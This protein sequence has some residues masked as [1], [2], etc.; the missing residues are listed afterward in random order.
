MIVLE[1]NRNP[2]ISIIIPTFNCGDF[3]PTAIESVIQQNYAHIEIVIIDGGSTDCTLDVIKKY[4]NVINE[5]SSGPDFGIYDAMN[6]GIQKAKGDWIYFLGADDILV[7]CLH[8]VA[9]NLYSARTIYY[10][11]VYLPGKNKVYS[12]KFN[13]HTLVSKNI[14]H[15]SIF[16]PRQVFEHYR[17]DLQYPILSDYDLNL[18]IWGEGKFKFKY[19]NELIAI[20]NATGISSYEKDNVF[21][22]NKPALISKYFRNRIALR[23]K[24]ILIRKSIKDILG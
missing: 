3:L 4:D 7:N 13:W 18:R 21:E 16:Y 10:G 19:I 20:H 9:R 8:K 14:N 1:S 11:D 24:M 22:A 17:F 23:E 5:W 2:L 12:G 15:Q 6:K